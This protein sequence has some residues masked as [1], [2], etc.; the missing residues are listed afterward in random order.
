[1]TTLECL[2]YA[3]NSPTSVVTTGCDSM[4]ILEQA[5]GAA[6]TFRPMTSSEIEALV[7]RTRQ[8]A[9]RG[10]FEL[11]KTTHPLRRDVSKPPVAGMG[12]VESKGEVM[13]VGFIGLWGTWAPAWRLIC[14]GGP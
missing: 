6:R 11:Y 2:Q 12:G 14:S 13:K 3:L 8:A 7:A 10:K 4:P 1:M 9:E 5:L